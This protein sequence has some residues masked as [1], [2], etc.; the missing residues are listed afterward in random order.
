MKTQL[1]VDV[2]GGDFQSS[3]TLKGVELFLSAQTL[4]CVHLF[5][6]LSLIEPWLKTLA[7]HARPRVLV[8][9]TDDYITNETSPMEALRKHPNS[10]MKLS[11]EAIRDQR[12]DACISA[13]NT[14]ALIALATL[15][16]KTLP[17]ISRPAIAKSLPVLNPNTL[18]TR[19]EVMMLDLGANPDSN[20]KNLLDNAFLGQTLFQT[21][22][23]RVP[24]VKLLNLGQEEIK[25]STIVKQAHKLLQESSLN[26]NGFIESDQILLGECDVIVTDGFSGNIA[27]KATEGLAQ[28]VSS[29][30]TSAF[31]TNILTKFAGFFLQSFFNQ[32]LH[33][34]NP[35]QYNGACLLGLKGIIV[36]SH[37]NSCPKSFYYALKTAHELAENR[38]LEKMQQ[39]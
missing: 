26:Y 39:I 11:I 3:T 14:G 7:E 31:Q 6:P 19:K 24:S 35:K 21:Q 29:K 8:H 16:L 22:Y 30:I 20:E 38:L 13:G 10:S 32:Q 36:K 5:G 15:I 18:S 23:H 17:G 25:G 37:G 27:L 2:M 9:H 4:S 1:A 33:A 34:F 12:V 28:I